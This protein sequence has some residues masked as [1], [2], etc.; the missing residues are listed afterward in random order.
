M[1]R[2]AR[3]LPLLPVS[4]PVFMCA[5]CGQRGG[6][7][8]LAAVC[9]GTFPLFYATIQKNKGFPGNIRWILVPVEFVCTMACTH[10]VQWRAVATTAMSKGLR[11]EVTQIREDIREPEVG[12]CCGFRGRIWLINRVINKQENWKWF[13]FCNDSYFSNTPRHAGDTRRLRSLFI[14][15]AP[16]CQLHPENVPTWFPFHWVH[17]HAL[18]HFQELDSCEGLWQAPETPPARFSGSQQASLSSGVDSC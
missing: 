8:W 9:V 3:V 6:G 10:T 4:L 16:L 15:D 14:L 17:T 13:L 5:G 11:D 7:G 1:Y 18:V 12:S 2:E